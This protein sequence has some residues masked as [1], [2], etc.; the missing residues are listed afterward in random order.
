[1]ISND[2]PGPGPGPP[3]VSPP[4]PGTLT[5]HAPIQSNDEPRAPALFTDPMMGM[6]RRRARRSKVDGSAGTPLSMFVE[7]DV[8]DRP[9]VIRLIKVGLMDPPGSWI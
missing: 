3:R 8:Q 5:I 9:E 1:M 4:L 7:E 6:R 2:T